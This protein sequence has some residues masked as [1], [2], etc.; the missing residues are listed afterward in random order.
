MRKTFILSILALAMLT[1]PG[2]LF[3][4]YQYI[5]A[6][7]P[8]YDLPPKSEIAKVNAAELEPLTTE[9]KMKVVQ[10]VTALKSEAAQLRV[11]LDSYNKYAAERNAEYKEHFQ[12]EKPWWKFK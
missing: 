8:V 5:E 2:C 10:T 1:T 11:I 9:T 4:R 12:T 6:R 7:Y 3:G